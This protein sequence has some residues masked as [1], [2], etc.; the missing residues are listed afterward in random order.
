MF[1][2]LAEHIHKEGEY[3]C[4]VLRITL[5]ICSDIAS[6]NQLSELRQ[7]VSE[8][9]WPVSVNFVGLNDFTRS[10]TADVAKI[11]SDPSARASHII[12]TTLLDRI[13]CHY[14]NKGDTEEYLLAFARDKGPMAA[15]INELSTAGL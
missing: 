10:L 6:E 15:F 9:G 11:L 3:G 5:H 4:T 1:R 13:T 2:S 8:R 7:Q 14:R 12:W